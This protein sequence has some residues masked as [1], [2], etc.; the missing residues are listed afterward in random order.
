MT[1]LFRVHYPN[2]HAGHHEQEIATR[3]GRLAKA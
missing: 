1:V 2:A 3:A